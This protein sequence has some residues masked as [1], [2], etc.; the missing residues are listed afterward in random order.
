MPS[1]IPELNP[2]VALVP[3]HSEKNHFNHPCWI[4]Q[5]P[6]EAGTFLICE[7]ETGRVWRLT[8][9]AGGESKSLWGDFRAE[10][11]PGPAIGLL[12]IAFHPRFREN[13]KYYI[14]HQIEMNGR[15]FTRISEK[16][17]EPDFTRDSGHPS[18]TIVEFPCSTDVHAGGCIEFGPD[19]YL[20]IGMGDTG[21]QGDPEGHAQNLGLMLGKMLRIDVDPRRMAAPTRSRRTIRSDRAPEHGRRS[22]RTAF[23]SRGDSVSI[24][25]RRIC[26]LAMSARTGSKRLTS[27]G[28]A[29]TTA[30]MCTKGLI[31]SR[32]ATAPKRAH[33][34]R[35]YSRTTAGSATRSPAVTST[36]ARAT[37]RS[38]ASTS[39]PTSPPNACGA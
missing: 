5:I 37:R 36:A 23:A 30:G 20:Y 1:N 26:G 14:Q 11:R 6:G 19:G 34:C 29:K 9:G 7:H 16:I 4:G 33:T 39:A 32:R 22:G 25:S 10:V 35:R 31:F 17:A 24:R 2:S 28:L 38:T 12:G 8:T 3:I 15:I 27:F 13:H 18:R 21:P